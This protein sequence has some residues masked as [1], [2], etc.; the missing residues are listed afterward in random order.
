MKKIS[1]LCVISF[2][3]FIS[4]SIAQSVEI[5]G[6]VIIDDEDI[7]GIHVINKTASKF[8]ITSSNGD[9]TIPAKLNDTIIFSAIKYKPKDVIINAYIIKSKIL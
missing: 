5:K 2:L 7:E 4:F 9:F 1:C 6:K 8:T 3:L